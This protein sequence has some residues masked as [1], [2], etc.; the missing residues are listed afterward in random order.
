MNVL[1]KWYAGYRGWEDSYIEMLDTLNAG[2]DPGPAWSATLYRR[3]MIRKT[4]CMSASEREQM[5]DFIWRFRGWRG[6]AALSVPVAIVST[7]G[8]ALHLTWPAKFGAL[9][10]IL[11][12][13][14]LFLSLAMGAV[15]TWFNPGSFKKFRGLA[16]VILPLLALTGAILGAS[17]ASMLNGE[18]PFGF[19]DRAGKG[20]VTAGIGLG[21][22][23]SILLSLIVGIRN[24]ELKV[25]NDR[26]A[27]DA[28]RHRL[29]MELT[30]SRLRLLQA[31]IEPHFLFNT[32]GAV[33]QAAEGRAPE[34]ATLTAHLIRFLRNSL[35]NFSNATTTLADELAIAESY[36]EIMRARLGTRLAYRIDVAPDARLCALHPT[37]LLT[38][39]ENA[40]KHGIEPAPHGG[41]VTIA[42]QRHDGRLTIEVTDTGVG[43]GETLGDG[44]GL[45]NVRE[46]LALAYADGATLE[47]ADN[48]PAGLVARLRVPCTDPAA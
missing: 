12:A 42:A 46:Q 23:Y 32:L 30:A 35:G 24:R 14:L 10:A 21:L 19:F 15:A 11:L 18:S 16:L 33:Q 28:D 13:N 48:H 45:R 29:G 40:I 44:N 5:R 41:A 7:L 3:R 39:V 47:L 36:L 2:R 38:L 20:I 34:A 17:V 8:F 9:E 43:M 25:I 6:W 31:Q 27:A 1:S 22:G 4:R 26:L 37:L